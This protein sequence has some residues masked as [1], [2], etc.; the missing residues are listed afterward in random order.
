MY[1]QQAETQ[2]APHGRDEQ[3]DALWHVGSRTRYGGA[4]NLAGRLFHMSAHSS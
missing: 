3:G 4:D 2:S 1:P